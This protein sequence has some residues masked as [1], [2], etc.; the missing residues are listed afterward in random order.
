MFCRKD[1]C[2]LTAAMYPFIDRTVLQRRSLSYFTGRPSQEQV[3]EIMELLRRKAFKWPVLVDVQGTFME[4]NDFVPDD[5]RFHY[6]LTD[7][8]G[9]PVFV[10]NPLFSNSLWNLFIRAVD[11][12]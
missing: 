4:L 9:R 6:F 12:L 8:D 10:G 5:N 1:V 7:A 3:Q 2:R 11:S